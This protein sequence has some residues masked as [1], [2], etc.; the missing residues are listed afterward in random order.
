MLNIIIKGGLWEVSLLK[1]ITYNKFYPKESAAIT[2][3]G[4]KK[5]IFNKEHYNKEV[6]IHELLHAF[7]AECCIHDA[8]LTGHQTEEVIASLLE[9][10]L[11]DIMVLANRLYKGLKCSK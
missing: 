2:V 7:T 3:R 4:S 6:V 5:I 11:K 9:H 10:S 8:D 1:D